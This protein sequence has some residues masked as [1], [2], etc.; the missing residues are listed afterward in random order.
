MVASRHSTSTEGDRE[1]DIVIAPG[2]SVHIFGGTVGIYCDRM[3]AGRGFAEMPLS[4]FQALLR[5]FG[6][7]DV[8]SAPS[9]TVPKT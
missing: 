9:A 6:S 8:L 7:V 5:H 3:E 4:D 1:L 2:I